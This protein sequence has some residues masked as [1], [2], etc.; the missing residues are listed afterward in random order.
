MQLRGKLL[1][2]IDPIILLLKIYATLGLSLQGF[3]LF[4][5][6]LSLLL[7]T[8]LRLPMGATAITVQLNTGP[9]AFSPVYKI[10]KIR[11]HY[12]TAEQASNWVCGQAIEKQSL[13]QFEKDDPFEQNLPLWIYRGWACILY[14]RQ[15]GNAAASLHCQ[16]GRSRLE[17]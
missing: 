15:I 16:A 10:K 4:L 8:Q 11:T 1:P 9:D 13:C 6:E 7:L 17:K 3:I 5:F 2:I 12:P 14:I